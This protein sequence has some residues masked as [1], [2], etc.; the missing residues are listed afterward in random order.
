MARE[1]RGSSGQTAGGGSAPKEP[2]GGRWRQVPVR[3]IEGNAGTNTATGDKMVEE[4]RVTVDDGDGEEEDRDEDVELDEEEES[5]MLGTDMSSTVSSF[6][7][8]AEKVTARG[9]LALSEAQK[10]GIIPSNVTVLVVDD[11]PTSRAVASRFL[12][13]ADLNVLEAD[14]GWAAVKQLQSHAVDL[15]LLDVFM[16]E[17]DGIQL[18]RLIKQAGGNE[19]LIIMMTTSEDPTTLNQCFEAGANDFLQK[20]LHRELLL[21]RVFSLITERQR[22]RK[23]R[24]YQRVIQE[25]KLR[26]DLLQGQCQEKEQVIEA[27]IRHLWT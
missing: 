26:G 25:E 9:S 13:R 23:E 15:V 6:P 22:K 14:G 11:D 19:T 1:D 17:V 18:L 8:V 7:P 12:R 10:A 20:P 16:P 4:E 2:E 24:E 27:F 5:K 21:S 3:I